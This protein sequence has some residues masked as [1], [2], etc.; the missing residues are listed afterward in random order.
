MPHAP[1]ARHV[2]LLACLVGSTLPAAAQTDSVAV[3]LDAFWRGVERS[4]TEW[5]VAAQ[6]ATYHPDAIGV[7][8]DAEEYRTSLIHADFAARQADTAQMNTSPLN[9]GLEFRITSRVHDAVTS[10]E[11][12]MYRFSADTPAGRR[13]HYGAVDSYLVKKD[14]RWL[15]LVEI[16][17][18]EDLTEAEWQAAG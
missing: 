1:P 12:G 17:R 5:S 15:I 2:W 14:G 7:A 13:V 10:H 11:V 9:P 4:V 6:R 8:G 16:Q 18:R 3:E